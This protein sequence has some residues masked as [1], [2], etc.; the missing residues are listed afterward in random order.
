MRDS[1]L[2]LAA[3]IAS[4]LVLIG[5]FLPWF[6]ASIPLAGQAS[7]NGIEARAGIT[8]AILA[9]L[10]L[11][12]L[13]TV[14]VS[15]RQRLPKRVSLPVLALGLLITAVAAVRYVDMQGK[16]TSDAELA[17]FA[18]IGIGLYMVLVGGLVLTGCAGMTVYRSFVIPASLVAL[19]VIGCGATDS[20]PTL[21]GSSATAAAAPTNAAPPTPAFQLPSEPVTFSRVKAEFGQPLSSGLSLPDMVE[22]ALRSL[23]EIQ[24]AFGSGTGF[25][26]NSDGLVVTNR[27]VMQGV[28]RANLRLVSGTSYAAQVVGEHDTLDLAYLLIDSGTQFMPIAVGDSDNVRVGES[29]IVIGFPIADRLGSEPTVSQ[30]IVSARRT[31]GLIQTDAPV[32]PGNSG[33]PML[34]QFGNVVGVVVSRVEEVGGRD[35]SGIG[36]A[37]PIN[38]VKADLGGQVTPG[39]ALPTP[40]P[41][42]R[43][44]IVP[45]IDLEATKTA[46]TAEDTFIQTK[47]AAEY[48][49]EQ[50]RLEAERF[51]ASLEA[52]RIAN[53]PTPTPIP[54]PT[55]EP[56]PTPLPT[57]TPHPQ[58]YCQEWEAM[59][60][61]WV[62]EGNNYRLGWNRVNPLVPDHPQLSANQAHG[63]CIIAFPDG[64]LYPDVDWSQVGTEAR[65]LLPGTYQYREKEGDDRVNRRNCWLRLNRGNDKES[66]IRLTYGEPFQFTFYTSHG[67]VDFA[68]DGYLYRVGE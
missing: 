44:T 7:I 68:C 53:R 57:P 35:I 5:S 11:L 19:M 51:A 64:R 6:T 12:V 48:Q 45:P 47:E 26:V 58:I 55:P 24:T 22:N 60:L 30:G 20:P 3:T 33:G 65:Q 32:N 59:V 15:A 13:G 21:P 52:T 63:F 50:D 2:I 4:F 17:A 41:T 38:E 27:H 10:S 56:T 67:L 16:L 36:F 14:L 29:V 31:G 46:L 66:E 8:T 34:D 18:S 39:E 42:A 9:V 28:D 37:I 54:T 25:I 49:A 61:N 1:R 40:V 23:V 43:P 62:R